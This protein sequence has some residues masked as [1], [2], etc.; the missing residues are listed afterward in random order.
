M[1]KKQIKKRG[2]LIAFFII[3][4]FLLSF[5]F[6]Q[7]S[8]Y[9]NNSQNEKSPNKTAVSEKQQLYEI[10]TNPNLTNEE[11]AEKAEE[12]LYAGNAPANPPATKDKSEFGG[13][14]TGII[15]SPTI[16]ENE[17]VKT[18]ILDPNFTN[19][20]K[21]DALNWLLY[22]EKE[23]VQPT[24]APQKIKVKISAPILQG[25]SKTTRL[26]ISE[27]QLSDYAGLPYFDA[28]SLVFYSFNSEKLTY[29]KYDIDTQQIQ[30]LGDIKKP[31][32]W[33]GCHILIDDTLYLTVNT[34]SFEDPVSHLYKLELKKGS[35]EELLKESLY[36]TMI[37]LDTDGENVLSYKGDIV[38]GEP[39]TYIEKTDVNT[40]RQEQIISNAG[41]IQNFS[42]ADDKIYVLCQK[43]KKYVMEIYSLSGTLL[44]EIDFHELSGLFDDSYIGTVKV[45][46]EY[47]F[48]GNES[49]N[50]ALFRLNHDSAELMFYSQDWE[51]ILAEPGKSEN[52]AL[53][54]YVYLYQTDTPYIFVID[55]KKSE[56]YR[57]ELLLDS[58]CPC[59]DNV[60]G[61]DNRAIVKV[62]DS[63]YEKQKT[64]LVEGAIHAK[65]GTEKNLSSVRNYNL[66]DD[67]K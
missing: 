18:I 31:T 43:D 52:P 41:A 4:I 55:V 56:V 34:D 10:I 38:N 17:M 35:M 63:A 19:D 47:I 23:T 49:L 30:E 66:D 58:E 8:I 14:N 32:I 12:L 20:Q 28:H 1:H 51:L 37:Y 27:L 33:S 25:N 48:I 36:Q 5:A 53:S 67:L 15:D 13:V 9:E 62:S 50:G 42:C 44:S 11:K 57:K 6:F 29:Y 54:S 22:T 2:V 65:D 60:M 39:V 40:G 16:P 59:L 24:T 45:F 21:T 7:L 64:Y 26:K 3:F 46:G 61:N